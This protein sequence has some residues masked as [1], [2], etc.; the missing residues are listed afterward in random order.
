MDGLG[1]AQELNPTSAFAQSVA[2]H[3]RTVPCRRGASGAPLCR[4]VDKHGARLPPPR[5]DDAVRR[6][7]REHGPLSPSSRDVAVDLAAGDDELG[8]DLATCVASVPTGPCSPA[9]RSSRPGATRE[10]SAASPQ[11]IREWSSRSRKVPLVTRSATAVSVQISRLSRLSQARSSNDPCA[12]EHNPAVGAG[13]VRLVGEH[14]IGCGARTTSA[15]AG[16]ADVRQDSAERG[17]VVAVSASDDRGERGPCPS[18][19]A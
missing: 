16:D 17:A 18:T 2:M 7:G 1:Q 8:D 11:A 3:L 15:Q 5:A 9:D 19:G 14:C 4:Q 10:E 6:D 12:S 13:R